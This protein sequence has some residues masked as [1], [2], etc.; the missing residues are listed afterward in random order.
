MRMLISTRRGSGLCARLSLAALMT[1]M[2]AQADAQ[3]AAS[4]ATP[5]AAPAAAK[6]APHEPTAKSQ[7]H[8]PAAPQEVMITA[9]RRPQR[10]KD[11]PIS[12]TRLDSST[13]QTIQ[14]GGGD[15]RSLAARVPSL[16]IESSFG[17]TFPRLYIRGLGNPDFDITAAQPVGV[18]YDD[19][20]LE[21]PLLKSFPIFDIEDV[22][23]LAGPQ[24]TLFGRN[25]PAGV[26]EDLLQAPDRRL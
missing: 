6:R 14:S 22:E 9:Q 17:R 12:V 11:V 4:A 16:N 8:P 25:T 18:Y 10:N 7:P 13:V 26:P 20:V 2:V 21:N 15:I 5:A 1:A 3:P 19:V 23:V 24:G